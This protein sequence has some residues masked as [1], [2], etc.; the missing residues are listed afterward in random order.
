MSIAVVVVAHVA[1][2]EMAEALTGK[3]GAVVSWDDGRLEAF[4]NHCQAMRMAAATGASHAVIV[5]DDAVPHPDLTRC[6]ERA[7]TLRP[8]DLI[9]LYVGRQR[10]RPEIT[11]P[12]IRQAEA[13]GSGWIEPATDLLWPVGYALPAQ[14]VDAVI[15][16]AQGMRG[17]T[18][19][20]LPAAWRKVTHRGAVLTWPSLL[21]HADG[22]SLTN[23]HPARQP[24][25]T[26][27]Q[28]GVPTWA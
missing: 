17:E 6:V 28:V 11:E 2:R 8:A 7:V 12:Y 16:A 24:G 19:G 3:L 20:R 18:A 15:E 4:G 10:P 5:E 22:P 26:A 14:H 13:T 1:R 9:G 21:D 27:W 25:R 23:E